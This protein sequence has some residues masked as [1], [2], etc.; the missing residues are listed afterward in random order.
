MEILHGHN[1]RVSGDMRQ[2]PV[3]PVELA[4]ECT[5]VLDWYVMFQVA[6]AVRE[7]GGLSGFQVLAINYGGI[8][9]DR[10]DEK[11]TEKPTTEEV[12]SGMRPINSVAEFSEKSV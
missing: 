4:G 2:L 5:S 1:N 12:W 11:L 3:A 7:I 6:L 9:G 10:L 8:Y